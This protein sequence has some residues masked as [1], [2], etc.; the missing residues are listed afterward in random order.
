MLT[1]GFDRMKVA[2]AG[3]GMVFAGGAMLAGVVKLVES[4]KELV[5][6][7]EL[8]RVAG[9]SNKDVALATSRAFE[10]SHQVMTTTPSQNLRMFGELRSQLGSVSEASEFLPDFA[11][12]V[13]VLKAVGAKNTERAAQDTIKALELS[14][15]MTGVDPKTGELRID[16]EKARGRM[17]MM[18]QAIIAGHGM[19]SPADFRNFASQAGPAARTMSPD[20]LYRFMPEAMIAM[21]SFKAGTAV[22]SL[23]SQMVG[24]IMTHP[25]ESELEKFNLINRE[26]V[27]IQRGGHVRLDEGAIVGQQ[28]LR[29]N[30]FIWAMQTLLPAMEAQGLNL[31]QQ[32]AE[33]YRMLGRQTTQRLIA[34]FIAGAPQFARFFENAKQSFTLDPK[35][36]ENKAFTEFAQHNLGT[37][38]EMATA[39]FTHLK[40]AIAV[41]G[42]PF[43]ARGFYEIARALSYL[44][45]VAERH[46]VRVKWLLGITAA[47]GGLLVVFGTLAVI[48]AGVAAIAA[49]GPVLAIMGGLAAIGTIFSAIGLVASQVNWRAMGDWARD[50]LEGA[51]AW[52]PRAGTWVIL[53]VRSF[54]VWA[55]E[56]YAGAVHAAGSAGRWVSEIVAGLRRDLLSVWTA[57]TEALLGFVRKLRDF[58]SGIAGFVGSAIANV[59]DEFGRPSK[60][61]GAAPKANEPAQAPAVPQLPPRLPGIHPASYVF[62]KGMDVPAPHFGIRNAVY[63]EPVAPW[64]RNERGSDSETRQATHKPA[65]QATQQGQTDHA[66]RLGEIIGRAI[67]DQLR[68]AFSGMQMNVDG[69]DFGRVVDRHRNRQATRPATGSGLPDLHLSPLYSTYAT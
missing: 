35:T 69:Q 2:A 61:P 26:K 10:V 13:S 4:S 65:H 7:Q 27:H 49:A 47:L 24:G 5:R 41:V 23:F 31:N 55:S 42:A 43:L 17:A 63:Q 21:G 68:G 64:W 16:P 40:E 19:L 11:R 22:T 12:I 53:F 50:L 29:D 9:L 39:Q 57:I 56:L 60:T 6:Q 44:S 36:G 32:I 3:F 28:Q 34:E 59:P 33:L 67:A 15:G 46:P 38:M 62:P 20:T 8:L 18:Q 52:A 54:G 58:A 25:V 48:G 30:P 1:G 14:G 37:A 45:G 66:Q 51:L